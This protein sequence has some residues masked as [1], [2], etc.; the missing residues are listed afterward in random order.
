MQ[1]NNLSQV[2]AMN[3]NDLVLIWATAN[4]Q[5]RT[6]PFSILSLA[7][8][9]AVYE[10][11]KSPGGLA[12]IGAAASGA[13]GDITALTGIINSR[14]SLDLNQL[15]STGW[16]ITGTATSN[17]PEAKQFLVWNQRGDANNVAQLAVSMDSG[18]FYTRKYAIASGQQVASWSAWK[19]QLQNGDVTQDSLGGT[20]VGKALF[21]AASAAAARTTLGATTLGSNLFLSSDTGSAQTLLGAGA[22]GASIFQATTAAAVR[23]LIMTTFGASLSTQGDA[24]GVFSL[25]GVTSLGKGVITTGDTAAAQASLGATAVGRSLFTAADAPTA[26]TAIGATATG[27][28]LLTAANAGV[29]RNALGAGAVGASVFQAVDQGTALTALGAMSNTATPTATV[30]GGVLLQTAI[31]DLTAA[32]TQTDFNGLL[33]KLRSS[34][35]LASS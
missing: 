2:S 10:L 13:N 7:A 30:R 12:G 16:F 20:T 35:L 6:A 32:P 28:S 19:T 25:L 1:M 9:D 18:K 17:Q 23:A 11:I 29:A 27:A 22:T 14:Q 31:T 5:A 4:G 15:D 34:G 33:A 3:P 26:A 8:R 21:T 24:N